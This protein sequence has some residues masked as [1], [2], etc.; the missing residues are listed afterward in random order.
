MRGGV[1]AVVRLAATLVG[2]VLGLSACCR[3]GAATKSFTARELAAEE[4]ALL[5]RAG[6]G[7]TSVVVA[8]FVVIGN[9]PPSTVREQAAQTV[10][11]ARDLLVRD[12]FQ[13]E[14]GV[15]VG[16]WVFRDDD[17]YRSGVSAVF[18]SSWKPETPYGYYSPC[19]RALVVNAAHGYGTLVHEMV[20]AYMDA[21]FADAPVWFNEGLASLYEQPS[22][23]NEEP[24]EPAEHVE[25]PPPSSP[26]LAGD[27]SL[28]RNRRHAH[29]VV[30]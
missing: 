7:Y 26:R 8:P 3:P 28:S 27:L 21:N 23:A 24:E 12:Y 2:I 15:I 10:A 6:A 17:S 9:G 20:H 19:E 30:Y 16:V 25:T 11:W 13:R 5:S 18:G 4:R 1:Q 22:C 29:E 14:L